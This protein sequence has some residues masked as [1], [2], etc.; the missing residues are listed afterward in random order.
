MPG[1][2]PTGGPPARHN[3]WVPPPAPPLIDLAEDLLHWRRR[4]LN[5]ILWTILAVR[6]VHMVLYLGHNQQHGL[7]LGLLQLAALAP[8]P[9]LF[10]LAILSRLPHLFR[11]WGFIGLGYWNLGMVV[12]QNHSLAGQLPLGLL[13]APIFAVVLLGRSSAWFAA[14]LST[15][16]Y[17]TVAALS[18]YGQLP[19]MPKS[20]ATSGPLQSWFVWI[21]LF[22]PLFVLLDL[23]TIRFR[24]LLTSEREYRMR[25]QKEALERRVLEGALL[26]TTERERQAVG[27][28]LHDGICQMITG[29]MLQCKALEQ[30]LVEDS[31]TE[32]GPLRRMTSM[33][34]NALGQ[35]RDL[36]QGLS[37]G[38][39][40]A[41]ALVPTLRELAR[42]LRESFELDCEVEAEDVTRHLSAAQATHL[43]RIAQE[44]AINAVKHGNP[45][46]ILLRLLRKDSNLVLE[47]QNDGHP[48]PLAFHERPGMGLR[49][50]QYR[51][52]LIGGTLER[53]D[54]LN[55]GSSIRCTMPLGDLAREAIT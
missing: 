8:I 20:L 18:H 30:T 55:W 13:T 2:S 14:A 28:E 19:P 22:A 48:W 23:F 4:T 6:L 29:A 37:P 32:I 16:M 25:L 10:C 45:R 35:A 42:R 11:G 44:S 49:I 21:V 36:A 40:T 46:R 24:R 41:E 43:Y 54:G 52:E 17:G 31:T 38:N 7:P 26:E 9:I 1:K 34:D 51:S 53:I 33:L 27:H 39:L 50:M 47:I 12:V 15:V 3:G 5:I